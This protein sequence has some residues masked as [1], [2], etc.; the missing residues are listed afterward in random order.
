MVQVFML[1]KEFKNIFNKA[2][3]AIGGKDSYWGYGWQG[4]VMSNTAYSG[5]STTMY[6]GGI[7]SPFVITEPH[8]TNTPELDIVKQFVHVSDMTPTI[9]EY[10]N[11]TYSGLEYK[12]NKSVQ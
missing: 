5:T 2:F 9:L 12:E 7:M 6:N 8:A 4:A 1:R 11:T 3:D 10:A